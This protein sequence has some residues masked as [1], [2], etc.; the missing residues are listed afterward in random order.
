VKAYSTLGVFDYPVSLETTHGLIRL[1]SNPAPFIF[2][3]GITDSFLHFDEQVGTPAL[4]NAQ[5][6]AAA[7]NA[8]ITVRYMLAGYM[9]KRLNL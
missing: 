5:N 9:K 8:G 1:S 3:S 4:A 7:Y 6:F 2:V